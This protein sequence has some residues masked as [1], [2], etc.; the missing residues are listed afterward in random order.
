MAPNLKPVKAILLD[1]DGVMT[2]GSVIIDTDGTPLRV[3]NEKDG[4]G[5]RMAA[6]GG[7]FLGVITGGSTEALRIRMAAYG[8]PRE[9]IWMKVR[10][11]LTRIQEVCLEYGFSP[12]EVLYM[13]DDIPD[14]A[15][16]SFAGV[17][18]VPCDAA[19]EAKDA[20]D[21]IAPVPGGKGFVRWTLEQVMKEQGK[22][23][24]DVGNYASLF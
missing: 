13:G 14:A 20:A 16:L 1:I 8:V 18:V 3:F 12:E 24:F 10:D 22:W 4:H 17:G 5:L 11:K 6:M 21:I 2:D 9:H 15:A 23:N 7:Y 19:Q